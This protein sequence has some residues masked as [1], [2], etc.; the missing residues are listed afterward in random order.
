MSR[1]AGLPQVK[2]ADEDVCFDEGCLDAAF[3]ILSA[4]NASIDPCKD[5]F[6]Y[7]CG[8]W[9]ANN[10]VPGTSSRWSRF[11]GLRDGVNNVTQKILNE[12]PNENDA[13]P[14]NQV[15][16]FYKTCLDVEAIEAAGLA[17]LRNI[18]SEF[19]GW[20]LLN[21]GSWNSSFDWVQAVGEVRRRTLQSAILSVY[22]S[23]DIKNTTKQVIYIDQPGF[24]LPRGVLI[25]PENYAALIA[26]YEQYIV[27]VATI[28]ESSQSEADIRVA[29]KAIIDFEV[30]MAKISSS[31]EDRYDMERI[32]NPFTL[33]QYQLIADGIDWK[34]YLNQ[35]FSSSGVTIADNEPIV[36]SETKYIEDL[37]PILTEAQASTV[38]NYI[39]WRLVSGLVPDTTAAMRD[40]T[41]RF[42]QALTGATEPAKRD[43]TCANAANG[44][45]GM[46]IGVKYVEAVFDHDAKS[47][48]ESLVEDLLVSFKEMVREAE[49]ME[50]VTKDEA[51][52][53]AD[54][55]RSFMAYPEWLEDKDAVEKYYEGLELGSTHFD[56]QLKLALYRMDEG[57]KG[58]R[59]PTNRDE[60]I[61]YP[62][63]VNAAYFPELN[64][65]TFPAG[66]LQ[67]P[68][69]GKLRPKSQNYG[70]IGVV[71]GHEITHGFDNQGAQFDKDGNAENWWDDKTKAEYDDRALCM[72]EQYSGFYAE[73]ANMNVNGELTLG[74]NIADNGGLR[75]SYRAYQKYLADNGPEGRL[76]GLEAL[77]TNQLFFLGYANIWCESITPEGLV[78]QILTDPHSPAEFRVKGPV[79]NSQEFADAYSCPVDS[80]GM[81]P[82]AEEKCTVW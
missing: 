52:A 54:A 20:Q 71:I 3:D 18:I 4:M 55:I 69:F 22:V 73:A 49:W 42:Q 46:A 9:L 67:P 7:S 25:A 34:K 61:M 58:L 13:L 26:A 77:S 17:P 15:K 30:S 78:N 82:P 28:L 64:S 11:N 40:A 65:I 76:P 53:K 59:Q 66:I 6:Q 32:Y 39:V 45:F 81:N 57:L 68:F 48:V 44:V 12:E 19:G 80:E 35:V 70:G 5:F 72:S 16:E 36:V 23:A 74:E 79:R 51:V 43:V 8:R 33:D 50:D 37:I 29:A 38:A 1:E 24:G 10:P 75:E 60:W 2:L 62:G 21:P 31:D 14:I 56:N 47:V 41:F 27:D 63:V